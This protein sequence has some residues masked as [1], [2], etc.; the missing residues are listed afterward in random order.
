[1]PLT[2]YRRHLKAC[3]VHKSKLPSRAK[4][5]Y[6]SCQCPIWIY[7]HTE[8]GT[9]IPR[10]STGLTD[11]AEAEALRSSIT[12]KGK[13]L[14]VHGPTLEDCITEYLVSRKHELGPKTYGQ[15]ALLLSRLQ[16][17]C[18]EKGKVF[19]RQLNVDLLEEFKTH[20]LPNL[21]N[22]SKGTATA[23]L[24]CFLRE[25]LRREWL[26]EPLADKVRPHRSTYEPAQPYS[27]EEVRKILTAA[28]NIS[29]GTHGYAAHPQTFRLLLDLML[30]TGLRVGDAIRYD[31]RACIKD[32]GVWTYTY[33]P[34][35]RKQTAAPRYI[36]AYLSDR[37]KVAIDQCRWLSPALPFQWGDFAN[38]AYL[39]NEVYERMQAIGVK[40][41]I[42]DCRPHRLRDT[43]AVRMLLKGME[44][45]DVSRLLGHSSV[46]VTEMH[47]ARWTLGRKRR[48]ARLVSDALVDPESDT[49]RNGHGD[50]LPPSG[51]RP[52]EPD[53]SRLVTKQADNRRF[54]KS[55]QLR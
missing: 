11:M 54:R 51:A 43:F 48:L 35:K 7:G 52:I 12:S 41:E 8:D 25:A 16:V 20:G 1:M 6:D 18:A 29:G 15:H 9:L 22:T 39:G 32:E 46:K 36:E 33:L 23:K 50:V 3:P 27:D 2:L 26:K 24:R 4:R 28:S 44:L 30:E 17:F 49:L 31:P 47:Y 40:H 14:E 42:A 37:L 53:H 55:P 19:I 34:Q 38:P 45:S 10:E 21:A 5:H 13:S